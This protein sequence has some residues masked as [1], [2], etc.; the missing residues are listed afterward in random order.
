MPLLSKRAI[1]SVVASNV[2]FL[3]PADE[4]SF[5]VRLKALS[6]LKDIKGSGREIIIHL[7]R[8]PNATELRELVALF[9]RYHADLKQL[10]RF[11]DNHAW[12]R[13]TRGYWY[14][15]MFEQT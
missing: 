11:A 3:S 2:V 6:C 9:F 13:D 15:N 14:R 4:E 1:I 8:E 7:R 12:L 5:F 10:A